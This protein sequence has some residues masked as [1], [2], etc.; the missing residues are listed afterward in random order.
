MTRRARIGY[1]RRGGRI[2]ADFIDSAVGVATSDREVNLKILR[3][4]AIEAGRL[5]PGLPVERAA[6]L[7][8]AARRPGPAGPFRMW[9]QCR[10]LLLIYSI[11]R[12]SLC[13]GRTLLQ[14]VA[15]DVEPGGHP[16]RRVR[17]G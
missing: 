10:R 16:H 6:R 11:L 13:R 5:D 8:E 2:N 12:R 15:G 4:L 9:K 7:R 3:A 17:D 1:S 14:P